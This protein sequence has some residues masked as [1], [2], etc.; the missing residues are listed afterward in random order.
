[1]PGGRSCRP[2]GIAVAIIEP[3]TTSTGIW[4]KAIDRVD[5]LIEDPAATRYRHRLVSFRQTLTK[6]DR[7]G[8][9]PEKVAHTIEQALTEGRPASRY[10]VG[11]AAKFAY[12]VR[13]FIP[14]SVFDRLARTVSS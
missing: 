9:S 7:S 11:L 5:A 10:P 12:R 6:A 2:E 14:D 1:M 8:M 4:G 13:P 3:G